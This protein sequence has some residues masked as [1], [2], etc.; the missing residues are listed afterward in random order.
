MLVAFP[1]KILQALAAVCFKIT[2]ESQSELEIAGLLKQLAGHTASELKKIRID[3]FLMKN[4]DIE[5]LVIQID[6][7]LTA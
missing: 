5:M 4:H 6:Q 3:I 1:D 7:Q 2:Y